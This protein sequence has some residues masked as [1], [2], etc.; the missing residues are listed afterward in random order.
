MVRIIGPSAPII[1]YVGSSPINVEE[2]PISIR[3]L[4]RVFFLPI[5]SPKCPKMIPPI[6]LAIN[7]AANVNNESISAVVA[8]T[9]PKKAVGKIRAAAAPYKKKSYHS[10][11]VPARAVSATFLIFELT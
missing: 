9:S 2:T 3:A 6:G 10:M 7:P 4:M 5:L 11:L 8:G 1:A